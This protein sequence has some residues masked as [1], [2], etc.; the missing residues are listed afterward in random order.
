MAQRPHAL[1]RE[2]D[3]P[4]RD[5]WDALRSAQ[6]RIRPREAAL[7][8]GVSEAELMATMCG[9]GARRLSPP[10]AAIVEALA[11]LGRV[12][13]Q[14]RTA[15]AVLEQRG[16]H[17]A[18]AGIDVRPAYDRWFV[19]YAGH[20]GGMRQLAFYDRSGTAV[21]K[22]FVVDESR[23]DAWDALARR[24]AHPVQSPVEQLP[25]TPRVRARP[26]AGIDAAALR[27]GWGAL[28]A[29]D[30]VDAL[31]A[32]H[33]VT[34]LQGLRLLTS[35]WAVSLPPMSLTRVLRQAALDATPLTI[36]VA[37]GG[38][39]QAYRGPVQRVYSSGRWLGARALDM[40]LQVRPDRVASAWLVRAP[41]F[42]GVTYAL[43]FFDA[44]GDP[45]LRLTG[46]RDGNEPD[47]DRWLTLLG[48]V[49]DVPQSRTRSDE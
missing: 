13:A 6:P 16:P 15:R 31:F 19:G 23:N 30:G 33:R 32:A 34:R 44:A 26:D 48:R 40:C 39:A 28:R 14:T 37:N 42:A 2:S 20:D 17:S 24:H 4:L 47:P 9:D 21:H 5:A 25:P 45:I 43:E 41:F 11:S 12:V 36:T 1:R 27:T 3:S 10:W 8:L 29:F 18:A 35:R 49:T 38:A 7:A 46:V 22:V